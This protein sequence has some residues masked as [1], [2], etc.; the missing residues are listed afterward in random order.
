MGGRQFPSVTL[1]PHQET[2]AARKHF[3]L[4]AGYKSNIQKSVAF[5]YINKK[6]T[7]KGIRETVPFMTAYICLRLTLSKKVKGLFNKN[8]ADIK[9][10]EIKDTTS[11]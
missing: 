5:L 2:P 11:R 7:E 10:E 4:S 9:K 6:W 1:K 8:I 3:Q